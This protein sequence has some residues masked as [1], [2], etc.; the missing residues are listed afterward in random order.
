[1][2]MNIENIKDIFLR[3]IYDDSSTIRLDPFAQM[4]ETI[5]YGPR[6]C[7]NSGC[8]YHYLS[9]DSAGNIYHVDG[10]IEIIFIL[11]GFIPMKKFRTFSNARST[12]T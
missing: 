9:L 2:K 10:L 7:E 8:L 6:T 5:E 11:E 12:I 3:W 1:M 4:I